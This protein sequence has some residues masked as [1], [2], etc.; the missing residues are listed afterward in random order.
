M[1]MIENEVDDGQDAE[2]LAPKTSSQALKGLSLSDL[3]GMLSPKSA[4]F[5]GLGASILTVTT[6]GFFF[7]LPMGI[8]SLQGST[9]IARTQNS[10]IEEAPQR[11]SPTPQ[12]SRQ[13]V[14]EAPSGEVPP[15]TNTDHVR[16]D[17]NA[18][19][20]WIEYSD[21]EC[22]FCKRFHPTMLKMMD[23][24]KGKV[25]WVYRHFPLSFH[26]NAQKE[27]EALECASALGGNEAFWKYLDKIFERTTS[28]GTGFALDQLVPLAKELGLN[29]NKFKACIDSGKYAAHVQTDLTG[30]SN[31]GVNGTPGSFLIGKDGKAQL[32]SGALP[33]GSIK[34]AID[35]AL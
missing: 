21:T 24:Y 19:L 35:A 11:P 32:I 25:K 5:A 33:Y 34:A 6:V 18:K 10:Q 3:M 8:R 23:E 9:L 27:D 28:N 13:P 14:P 31:A 4:F 16:G 1:A 7:L 29:E 20:T 30:G 15:V 12:P 22:P 2:T 26:Q 17:K